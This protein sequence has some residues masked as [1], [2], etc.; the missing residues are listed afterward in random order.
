MSSILVQLPDVGKNQGW[1]KGP[2]LISLRFVR[3]L[4]CLAV[5]HPTPVTPSASGSTDNRISI[6][7]TQQN[8]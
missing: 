4:G 8:R 6:N 2:V 7:A 5:K 1:G 3:G